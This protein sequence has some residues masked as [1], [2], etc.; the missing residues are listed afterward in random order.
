MKIQA[1]NREIRGSLQRALDHVDPSVYM[2]AVARPSH[3]T[4]T[5]R[6]TK[7]YYLCLTC[8]RPTGCSVSATAPR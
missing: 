1:S 8:A 4:A 2:Y 3:Q 5:E 7:H 6:R